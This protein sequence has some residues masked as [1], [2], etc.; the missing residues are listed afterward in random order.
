MKNYNIVFIEG[1]PAAGKTALWSLLDG[2]NSFF[3]DPLHTYILYSLHGLFS[4]KGEKRKLT[5]REVRAAL[6]KTEYYKI[7]QY[8]K[9]KTFPI[10]FDSKTQIY[11]EYIFDWIMFDQN[12]INDVTSKEIN[13]KDF[14]NFYIYW[15]LKSY[16]NGI[17]LDKTETFITMTNYFEYNKAVKLNKIINCQ[18]IKVTRSPEEII[19][20]RSSRKPRSEDGKETKHFAPVFFDLMNEGEYE[21]ICHFNDFYKKL[22]DKKFFIN[23][24]L[25]DIVYRKEKTLLKLCKFLN[26]EFSE[27]LII[28]TRDGV[29]LSSK[30]FLTKSINDIP[31][32]SFFKKTLILLHK[33]FYNIFRKPF[34]IL[35]LKSVLI[36]FGLKYLKK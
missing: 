33:F 24:N 2:H 8:S 34:N 11:K 29:K 6:S 32:F 28:E 18:F 13:A 35:S 16:K 25:Y 5:I 10:S 23:V 1:W 7:E 17:Y 19:Y 26:I 3:V 22:E 31:S 36:Y 9:A 4:E 15:Y 12:F 30:H 20:S 14:S 21:K 27:K